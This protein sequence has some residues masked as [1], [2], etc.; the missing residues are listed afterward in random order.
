MI[1]FLLHVML[2]FVDCADGVSVC[3]TAIA[4]VH[5]QQGLMPEGTTFVLKVLTPGL[6]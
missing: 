5:G 2:T 1:I 4:V 3:C 6:H